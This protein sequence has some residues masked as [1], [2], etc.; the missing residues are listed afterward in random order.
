MHFAYPNNRKSS[1]P[2]PYSS[3]PTL[4]TFINS[5]RRVRRRSLAIGALSLLAFF[6]ILSKLFGSSPPAPIAPLPPAFT[7]APSGHPN[8]VLVTTINK[9]L[10]PFFTDALKQ[11]RVDYAAKH[12]MIHCDY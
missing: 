10:D 12:G 2:P 8:V 6:Y 7:K 11:N 1:H 9:A 4:S 3:R 5:L